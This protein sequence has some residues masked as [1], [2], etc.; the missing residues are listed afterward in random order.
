MCV[1]IACARG[2]ISQFPKREKEEEEKKTTFSRSLVLVLE[3]HQWE[4]EL[5]RAS[6]KK[7]LNWSI[8][9]LHTLLPGSLYISIYSLS[10]PLQRNPLLLKLLFSRWAQAKEKERKKGIKEGKEEK[11]ALLNFY[12][13]VKLLSGSFYPPCLKMMAKRRIVL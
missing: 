5:G 11:K 9:T 1:C 13:Q 2:S 3:L 4:P 6:W 12:L 10:Q 8:V 7:G